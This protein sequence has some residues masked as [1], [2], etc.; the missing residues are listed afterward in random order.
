MKKLMFYLILILSLVIYSCE[1]DSEDN[2]GTLIIVPDEVSSIQKAV[3]I[4][5]D[6]DTILLKPG[7]Y[8]E[9]V[10]IENKSILLTSN[11][12][13]SNDT[14][15]I[16]Q[17]IINGNDIS[18][19]ICIENI[20]D[21]LKINGL[22]IKNGSINTGYDNC[23]GGGI[24]CLN[25]N[26]II[27]N[28]LIIDN[29]AGHPMYYGDGGGLY[30][31]NSYVLLDNVKI[32]NNRALKNGAALY[33]YSSELLILNSEISGNSNS[34]ASAL[35]IHSSNFTVQNTSI[36]N[37]S[38]QD[39]YPGGLTICDIYVVLST[40]IFIDCVITNDNYIISENSDVEFVNTIIN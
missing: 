36:K 40:G 14:N 33:S 24:N 27:K 2:F 37:N 4:A 34:Y 39:V 8:L 18:N 35:M 22:I 20:T 5:N 16:N 21:T 13:F 25:S 11:Y 3:N 30:C 10:V 17:T 32:S 28:S 19:V 15:D 12:L 31:D 7:E 6:N 38:S 26:L 29:W 23:T 9:N 1:E